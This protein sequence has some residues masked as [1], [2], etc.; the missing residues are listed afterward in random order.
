M[1]LLMGAMLGFLGVSVDTDEG[2]SFWGLMLYVFAVLCLGLVAFYL[3]I[4]SN[5]LALLFGAIGDW[6]RL[7]VGPVIGLAAKALAVV[8]L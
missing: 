8:G 5:F 7:V 6:I 1:P 4:R 3:L 2:I